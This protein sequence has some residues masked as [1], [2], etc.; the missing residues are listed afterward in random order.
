MVSNRGSAD[1]P[2]PPLENLVISVWSQTSTRQRH[3]PTLLENLVISVWS[4]TDNGN[5][6]PDDE[7]ENLVISVWSQTVAD[8]IS[9]FS[10]LRTL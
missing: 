4:Q 7:L 3:S 10:G 1:P 2:H 6:S 8:G 9:A 5:D